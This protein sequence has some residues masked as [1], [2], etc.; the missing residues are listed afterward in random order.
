MPLLVNERPVGA[1]GS[2]AAYSSFGEAV[3]ARRLAGTNDARGRRIEVIPFDVIGSAMAGP[4]SVG[5]PYLN[6]YLANG[7]VVVPLAGGPPDELALA[8]LKDAFPDGAVVGVPGA[9]LSYGGGPHCITQQ[10]PL[11]KAVATR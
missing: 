10:M 9:T 11:G 1:L 8:R 5:V 7:A 3:L 2:C 4:H 6:C